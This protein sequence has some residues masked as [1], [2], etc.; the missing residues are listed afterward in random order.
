MSNIFKSQ[1]LDSDLKAFTAALFKTNSFISEITNEIKPSFNRHHKLI[2]T[3]A[4]IQY[5]LEQKHRSDHNKYAF[6]AEIQSDLLS[7]I[8]LIFLGFYHQSQMAIRRIIE[9]F[10][11]QVYYFYHPVEF[12]LLNNGRNEYQPII[13]LKEFVDILPTLTELGDK[14]IKLFNQEV[15]NHYHELCR[16]VHTKGI[17]FMG[18]AKTIEEI[19]TLF[20]VKSHLDH[21]N[22]IISKMIYLF[23]KIYE[24]LSFTNIEKDLIAKAFD[25]P[26]RAALLS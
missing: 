17:K 8:S 18:L 2:Y 1:N 26:V 21:L 25:R 20:D 23:Y 4:L 11:N 10:Y 5:K 9:N 12:Q 19:K 14:N 15:F 3:I 13:Q 22:G 7:N 6:L 24:D 16:T